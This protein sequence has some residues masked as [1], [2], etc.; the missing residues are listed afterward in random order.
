MERCEGWVGFGLIWEIRVGP[1][2]V[3]SKGLIR[4]EG[5][6]GTLRRHPADHTHTPSGLRV[7]GTGGCWCHSWKYMAGVLLGAH[8]RFAFRV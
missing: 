5:T 4:T 7:P 1:T 8:T 2:K 3:W 6:K